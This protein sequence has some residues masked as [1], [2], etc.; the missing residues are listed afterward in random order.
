MRFYKL[1]SFLS[2]YLSVWWTEKGSRFKSFGILWTLFAVGGFLKKSSFPIF[3]I[4]VSHCDLVSRQSGKLAPATGQCK[5]L[6]CLPSE[7]NTIFRAVLDTLIAILLMRSTYVS[8]RGGGACGHW[9]WPDYLCSAG[10]SRGPH[11][12]S[13]KINTLQ[14]QLY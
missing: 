1:A 13:W 10:I 7:S 5:W 11:K 6:M 14:V 12:M 3:N 2:V 4:P 8:G 9:F